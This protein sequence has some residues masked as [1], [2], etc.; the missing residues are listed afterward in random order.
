V[1]NTLGY[2][3]DVCLTA[4]IGVVVV[5]PRRMCESPHVG[6]VSLHH[7]QI[8]KRA[9]CGFRENTIFRPLGYQAPS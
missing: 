5:A 2:A 7:V 4:P 1:I 3:P 6:A 9:T 8:T